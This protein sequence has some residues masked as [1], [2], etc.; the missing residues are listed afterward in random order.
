MCGK[1][2]FNLLFEPVLKQLSDRDVEFFQ[3]ET[4]D[5]I[6]PDGSKVIRRLFLIF[7]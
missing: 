6:K 5:Y 7:S 2:K 1:T 4:V 3:H